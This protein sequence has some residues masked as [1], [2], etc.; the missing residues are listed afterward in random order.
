MQVLYSNN[1]GGDLSF[2]KQ[3][4]ML[5]ARI[6]KT[7]QLYFVY[8]QYL[9]E[10]CQYSLVDASKRANKFILKEED[11]N[12]NTSIAN[13]SIIKALNANEEFHALQKTHSVLGFMDK[14]IIKNMF[15]A[16]LKAP[17]YV[18]YCEIEEK[19][20][21]ND[22]EILRY[23]SKKV[24]G[25]SDELDEFLAEHF[26][27]L[28]DD[29]FITLHSLQ[30]KF[31]E[32]ESDNLEV[33]IRSLLLGEDDQEEIYFSKDLLAKCL[34]MN[35]ELDEI[36]KPRLKNWDIERIAMMDIV[37]IKQAICEFLYFP[38]IPLK[39]SMNEY[40]DISKEYSTEK[41]KDF[42]NGILD[43][44]MKDLNDKGKIKKLGRGLINN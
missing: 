34:E 17:K 24:I 44:V 23:I 29:H 26:M 43:K 39:V 7:K 11:V 37:L 40:I 32:Y 5:L 36:I 19:T 33:F 9:L 38:Y 27:S 13:N 41:S 28:E 10:I 16:L 12:V 22:A 42:I 35:E 3:E 31:K 25:A 18:K 6:Q 2:L 8:L 30:K 20:K 21:A 14:K 15:N 1:I 4:G